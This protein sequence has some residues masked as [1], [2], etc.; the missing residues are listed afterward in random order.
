MSVVSLASSRALADARSASYSWLRSAATSAS[1]PAIR[2]SR[3]SSS[4]LLL[5]AAS[6]HT[7]AWCDEAERVNNGHEKHVI[8]A[9][10]PPPKKSKPAKRVRNSVLTLAVAG[11]GAAGSALARAE[12]TKA[13]GLGRKG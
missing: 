3:S 6:A 2:S 12:T 10:P 4:L 5:S 9:T 1:R 8:R 11:P 13:G 7:R